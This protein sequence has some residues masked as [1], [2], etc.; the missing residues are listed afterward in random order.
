LARGRREKFDYFH[1]V[2]VVSVAEFLDRPH[3]HVIVW[4]D[5]SE[6]IIAPAMRR[7]LVGWVVVCAA[8]GNKRRRIDY[9]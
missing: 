8:R 4:I 7:A 9:A 6:R 1:T 5:I 3:C 2:S